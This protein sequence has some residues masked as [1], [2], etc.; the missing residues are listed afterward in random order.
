M[1]GLVVLTVV[2]LGW[3]ALQVR[4]ELEAARAAIPPVQHALTV[5]DVARARVAAGEVAAHTSQARRLSS[6]L[7]WRVAA[8]VP[9]AGDTLD[10]ISGLA[11][12]ADE[13]ASGVVPRLMDAGSAFD[14]KRLRTAGDRVAVERLTR[15]RPALEE[16]SADLDALYRQVREMR[17][18]HMVPP[19]TRA[20]EELQAEVGAVREVTG[21][22]AVASRLLPPILGA[23][24][25]RRYLLAFQNNAEARGTGGLLGAYGIL[26]ARDGRLRLRQL[27]P[28]T[29][30]VDT[31]KDL[32]VALGADFRDRYGDDPALWANANMSPHFPYAARIW[33]ALW[34]RQTGQRLD[35][36]VATDPVAMGYVLGVTGP[37]RLADG[38]RVTG[39]NAARL[40]MSEAYARFPEPGQDTQRDAFL[41]Q[42]A[43]AA[44]DRLFSG[45][46]DPRQLV[47]AMSRAAEEGRL[48]AYSTHP[49]EQRLLAHTVVGGVLTDRPGPRLAL[50]VNNGSGGKLDYYLDRTVRYTRLA[51]VGDRQR[52][53]VAVTLRNA[54]PSTGLPS[55]VTLRVDRRATGRPSLV[56]HDRVVASVFLPVGSKVI[57]GTRDGGPLRVDMGRERGRP[58]V[59]YT[60]DLAPGEAS[61]VVLHLDEPAAAGPGRV[62]TQ[63]LVR[64]AH[65]TVGASARAAGC[66]A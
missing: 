29:E 17:G 65:V 28:N 27:G 39:G 53:T 6:S 24:G 38:T 61:T 22:A 32:P 13:V 25:P 1:L 56:G 23:D 62:D 33:L 31:A 54:A 18:L 47:E 50:A 14:A 12:V 35:G 66:G 37:A 55:Y 20:V 63:P 44:F 43:R 4:R 40:T 16:A 7:G 9:V 15:V 64:P 59:G 3:Q 10:G 36:V 41:Q 46:G 8:A 11:E 26:D 58:V 52:S 60:L 5:G 51:C 42:V 34:K 48:L 30:L 2:W 49:A 57:A 21:D 19:V 45:A